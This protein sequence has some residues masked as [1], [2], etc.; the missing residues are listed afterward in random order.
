L[1]IA[2]ALFYFWGP[3]ANLGKQPGTAEAK[4][5]SPGRVIKPG[6]ASDDRIQIPGDKSEVSVMMPPD[7]DGAPKLFDPKSLQ[8]V[9]G[10]PAT[11]SNPVALL[12]PPALRLN[13]PLAEYSGLPSLPLAPPYVA[14]VAK[15]V[16]IPTPIAVPPA[17][18]KTSA[19]SQPNEPAPVRTVR[20]GGSY[21]QPVLIRKVEP[22]YPAAAAEQKA[23]GAVSF[24]ATITKD[25]AVTNLKLISGDPLLSQAAQQAISQWKFRPAV[26]NGEPVEVTQ[27]IVVK[28]NLAPNP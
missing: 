16:P 5:V 2:G 28:F 9:K 4:T 19:P 25:G 13:S 20:R 24:Q 26:L 14:P 17:A 3:Y 12:T 1:L 23:Q 6:E 10:T 18:A 8:A 27:T 7:D 21:N 11:S 15:T 22:V